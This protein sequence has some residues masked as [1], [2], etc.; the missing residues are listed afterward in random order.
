MKTVYER[1]STGNKNGTGLGLPI[2][3]E[4]AEQMGGH[5]DIN[6]QPGRGTTVWIII[7]CEMTVMERKREV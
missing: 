7:P 3:K 6:S 4:L 5:I 1:F 2:S